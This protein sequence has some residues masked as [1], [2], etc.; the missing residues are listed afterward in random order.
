[1]RLTRQRWDTIVSAMCCLETGIEDMEVD[2]G[3]DARRERRQ[4]E[5]AMEYVMSIKPIKKESE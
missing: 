5:S 4:F 1:M 2:G 3:S